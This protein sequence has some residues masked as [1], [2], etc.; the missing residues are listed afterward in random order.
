MSNRAYRIGCILLALF[1]L[2]AVACDLAASLFGVFLFD[3]PGSENNPILLRAY[4]SLVSLPLSLGA[5]FVLAIMG[6]YTH[7]RPLG[8]LSIFVPLPHI[9]FMIWAFSQWN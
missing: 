7:R 4:Y 3:A 5:G 1:W 8:M 2:L 9:A 6:A